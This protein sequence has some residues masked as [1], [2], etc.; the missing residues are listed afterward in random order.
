VRCAYEVISR[1]KRLKRK[2]SER[3]GGKRLKRR[4]RGRERGVVTVVRV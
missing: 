1:G 2:E 4:E 3:K